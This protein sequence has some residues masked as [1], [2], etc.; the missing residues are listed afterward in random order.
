[1]TIL[2]RIRSRVGLLVGII[3]L[4]LLAFVL[5]DLFNSQRGIFGGGGGGDNTVG[6]ING[7][8]VTGQDF[9]AKMDEYSNEK[10]LGKQEQSQLSD[11]VWEEM[12]EKYVYEPQYNELGIT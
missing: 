2:S 4:A 1:M 5:T 3:F 7:H 12:L 11:A 6:I 10:T 9:R 8:T